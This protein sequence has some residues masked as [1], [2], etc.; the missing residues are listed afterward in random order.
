[1]RLRE[2]GAVG[3]GI[4]NKAKEVLVRDCGRVDFSPW[5][6]QL[7]DTEVTQPRFFPLKKSI[8]G[9]INEYLQNGNHS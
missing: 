3:L 4:E 2:R 1:M 7:A 6:A 5:Q 8:P 9:D